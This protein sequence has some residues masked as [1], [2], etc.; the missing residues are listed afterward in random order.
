M[1][2][3]FKT[4][5]EKAPYFKGI[6]DAALIIGSSLGVEGSSVQI[7]F[8]HGTMP[9]ITKDGVTITRSLLFKGK[10]ENV[11]ATLMKE[12]AN[13]TVELA[14]DG[15]TT[16]VVLANAMIQAGEKAK[17][18]G[19]KP[20]FLKQGIN[21]AVQSIVAYLKANSEDIGENND[22]ILNIATISTNNDSELGKIIAD[23]YEKTG[24]NG[25][26]T[27]EPSTTEE[28]YAKIVDGFEFKR[29]WLDT[30]FINTEKGKQT[31]FDNPHILL[32]DYEMNKF[33]EIEHLLKDQVTTGYPLVI[34]AKGFGGNFDTTVGVNV[35]ERRLRVCLIKI[36]N[37]YQQEHFED[38]AIITGATLISDNYGM[39]IKSAQLKH[40]GSC[41]KI[42]VTDRSTNIIN[43]K[44]NP[45]I[46][47]N[48][49]AGLLVEIEKNEDKVAKELIEKRLA[50]LSGS[51]GIIYVG[52]K[53]NV[54]AKEKYDRVDDALRAVK[55]AIEEGVSV[56]GGIALFK[57][58]ESFNE[59]VIPDNMNNMN[60]V[61][62]GIELIRDAIQSPLRQMV[63]NAGLNEED[64]IN[65]LLG[66]DKNIG[67]NVKTD[68]IE[69]LK[70]RGIIDPTKVIRVALENAA[71]IAGVILTSDYLLIEMDN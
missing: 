64:V 15:T 36:P 34:I 65:E 40:L 18:N 51:I 10:L 54:E 6:A 58:F 35:K 70:E 19:A 7:S 57:S 66:T 46:V 48:H 29:G 59:I 50:Q 16:T 62:L 8:S 47:L 21:L 31:V 2:Q 3:I 23:A 33:E 12:I 30:R 20:R 52:G 68:I 1:K 42:V 45:E 11:G 9:L 5:E 71:S 28:T 24:K 55:S 41:E 56:G 17:N 53:T 13:K 14:G 63:R 39:K 49:K 44:G 4:T 22:K 25:L 69:N 67:Y 37:N 60:D 61:L 32:V 38:L 43:G 27:P 26:I